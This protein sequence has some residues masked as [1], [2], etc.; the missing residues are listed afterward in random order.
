MQSWMAM[1]RLCGDPEVRYTAGEKATAIARFNLAV[2]KDYKREGQPDA[3]FFKCVT[4]GK[5]SEF[6]EKYLKKGTKIVVLGRVENDNYVDQNT[7]NK[8]YGTRVTV[9]KISFAESKNASDAN[10][11]ASGAN[12][13]TSDGYMNLPD[14]VEDELPFA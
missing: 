9:D 1:G 11:N 5:L 6:V 12:N 2:D 8:V 4:F 14:G 13:K 7:G 3:D 10:A